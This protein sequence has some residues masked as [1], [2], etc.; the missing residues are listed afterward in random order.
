[1][2][3]NKGIRG[4]RL[5]R[6]RRG[7]GFT[8]GQVSLRSGVNQS[9]ISR[10]E[11]GVRSNVYV[12]TA[13]ALARALNTTTDYLLGLTANPWPPDNT[14]ERRTQLEYDLLE[15]FRKLDLE[16]QRYALAQLQMQVRYSG[17]HKP[18]IVGDDLPE[19]GEKQAAREDHGGFFSWNLNRLRKNEQLGYDLRVAD[20]RR[21]WWEWT[22]DG[23]REIE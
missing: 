6:L 14:T 16:E 11:R 5:E 23:W 12:D 4:D 21:R 18:R 2:T 13:G 3:E 15:E 7:Q 19:E 17:P 20:K 8:Q 10:L 9:L 22:Y 1:M